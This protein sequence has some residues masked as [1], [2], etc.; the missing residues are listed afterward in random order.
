ML[1]DMLYFWN[2]SLFMRERSGGFKTKLKI[3]F[4]LRTF[5]DETRMTFT[6]S[7]ALSLSLEYRVWVLEPRVQ[8]QYTAQISI[9]DRN[10]SGAL[11]SHNSRAFR[12]EARGV[13]AMVRTSGLEHHFPGCCS[14]CPPLT[15]PDDLRRCLFIS[16]VV[17]SGVLWAGEGLTCAHIVSRIENF[18]IYLSFPQWHSFKLNSSKAKTVKYEELNPNKMW[19]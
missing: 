17:N 2:D 14:V 18:S 11:S 1:T 4:W 9:L 12:E 8:Q 15:Q 19:K 10:F 16:S 13:Q 6:S 3:Y 7:L 5:S